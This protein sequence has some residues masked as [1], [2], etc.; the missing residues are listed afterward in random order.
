M[1][2]IHSAQTY[3]NETPEFGHAMLKHFALDPGYLNLNNGQHD[4]TVYEPPC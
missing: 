2:L 3:K 1:Q 4:P